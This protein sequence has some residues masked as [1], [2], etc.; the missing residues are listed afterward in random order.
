MYVITLL[1]L[2]LSSLLTAVSDTSE[3]QEEE[4]QRVQ[5]RTA[6][7]VHMNYSDCVHYVPEIQVSWVTENFK[8]RGR[9]HHTL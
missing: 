8:K 6:A 3:Q 4:E 7:L 9:S 2:S 5:R 1:A